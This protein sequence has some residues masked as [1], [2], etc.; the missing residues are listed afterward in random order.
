[1]HLKEKIR[2]KFNQRL[3]SVFLYFRE[4]LSSSGVFFTFYEHH[5]R[6]EDWEIVLVKGIIR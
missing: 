2:R 6:V 5:F 3:E 4:I 1:M